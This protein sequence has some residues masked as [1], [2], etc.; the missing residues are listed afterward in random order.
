MPGATV[1]GAREHE[2]EDDESSFLGASSVLTRMMT[3]D[4]SGR[5]GTIAV[6]LN[7]RSELK[8]SVKP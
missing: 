1:P 3:E 5:A 8:G 6:V 4:D 2:G 7:R